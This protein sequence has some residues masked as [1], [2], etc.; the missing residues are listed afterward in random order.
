MS[1]YR[2]GI[3]GCGKPWRT[4]GATGF[5]M[6]HQH[7]EGYKASSDAAIVALADISL[8]NAR[9]FQALHGGDALYDDYR[10]M[11]AN[12]A[13]DIVSIST[14]PHLHAEM[15]IAAAEAG[16]KAIHCEKPMAPTYGESRR[17][18]EVC[19][20]HGVQLTF[21]HQ[22]RF[23]TPFRRA[24]ELL[25][26]GAIGELRRLEGTTG[27]LFDWGTHWFDMLFFYNDETPVEWV[28]GQIDL[29]GSEKVFGVPIEGQGL[30]H[31]RFANGVE[32]LMMTGQGA[33]H[34]LLNRLIGSQGMIEVGFSDDTPLRV[35]GTG[36]SG[37]QNIPVDE[38]LHGRECVKRGVLDLIDA[39]KNGREPEL[40][41]RRALRTTELIFATYE[42]SRRRARVDLPLTIDD[43]PLI[44]M[45]AADTP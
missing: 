35:W 40:A 32:G 1:T 3:I 20:Q 43:S 16:V 37:W 11:L 21:N 26:A 45:L 9:A 36:Q 5:G 44:A 28:I 17:M 39:L 23:G 29:R 7:A 14:W 6:S 33:F 18:V 2:V 13:L 4:E 38:G 15:V 42:S 19:E 10:V 31:F 22:R 41:A 25:K 30:S 8:E 34:P 24:K 12:E 27:N